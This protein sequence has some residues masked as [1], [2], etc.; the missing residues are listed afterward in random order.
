MRAFLQH[1]LINKKM[2]T[3]DEHDKYQSI[4]HA[5]VGKDRAL[6]DGACIADVLRHVDT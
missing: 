4:F 1:H 5:L 3:A 2:V 6:V